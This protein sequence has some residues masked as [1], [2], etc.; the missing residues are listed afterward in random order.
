MRKRRLNKNLLSCLRKNSRIFATL[1]Q[2]LMK[3]W[4]T[5]CWQ[6]MYQKWTNKSNFLAAKVF[7]QGTSF[8]FS[9]WKF[10]ELYVRTCPAVFYFVVAISVTTIWRHNHF[11]S[12]FCSFVHAISIEVRAW[13]HFSLLVE[14]VFLFI[15]AIKFGLI[16][17]TSLTKMT[18]SLWNLL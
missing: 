4:K 14:R 5:F 18:S 11:K 15:C 10:F 2:L 3:I 16:W 1:I 8:L 13:R 17:L 7:L 6:G 9:Q 12:A